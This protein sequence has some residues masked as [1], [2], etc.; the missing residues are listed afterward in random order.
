MEARPKL[1]LALTETDKVFEMIG[2][3]SLLTLWGLTI[4]NYANLPD[5]IPIHY[6]RAGQ[7]DG[8]GEKSTIFYCHSLR[9]FYS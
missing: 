5:T 8:F 9:L 2:W 6:N 4:I 7:V 1:K 3:L